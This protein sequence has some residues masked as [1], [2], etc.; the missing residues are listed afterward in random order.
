MLQVALLARKLGISN[1][2]LLSSARFAGVTRQLGITSSL[3]D[4][5][6]G[7]ITAY[8]K[9][10][11]PLNTAVPGISIIKA[12]AMADASYPRGQTAELSQDQPLVVL[13]EGGVPWHF[14]DS[15]YYSS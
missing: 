8:I 14:D 12:G 9:L 4:E 7:S 11:T 10:R 1:T 15:G 3:T 13:P 2:R 6:A 5:E